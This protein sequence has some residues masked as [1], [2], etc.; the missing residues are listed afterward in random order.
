MKFFIYKT[1]Y[2]GAA[3]TPNLPKRSL[4]ATLRVAGLVVCAAPIYVVSLVVFYHHLSPSHNLKFLF[5]TPSYDY[6]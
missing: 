1:T 4:A 6:F 2:I 3:P 5:Q